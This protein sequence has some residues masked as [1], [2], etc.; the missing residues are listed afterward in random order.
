MSPA[1]WERAP[2]GA[3]AALAASVA[4]AVPELV[5]PRLRLR[6]PRLADFAAYAA[7]LTTERGAFVGGPMS[8][9]EAWHDFVQSVAGWQL[10]GHGTWAVERR[11]DGALLGFITL[12][13]EYGD[14]EPEL[15][16]LLL[17]EAEGRGYAREAA[18]TA[19]GFAFGALGWRSVVSYVAPENRR[20]ARLAE[21]LG[22]R[23]EPGLVQ[24]CSVWR[25]NA[26]EGLR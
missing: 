16:F 3:A 19:R 13:H 11:D 2:T 21:R 4:A 14:P 7:I 12:N 24:G 22:A 10:R 1:P 18:E 25:H 5:T 8:R 23:M 15:G 17:T 20:S 26:A 9:E 6:A